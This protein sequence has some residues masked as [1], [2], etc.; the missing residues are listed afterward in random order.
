MAG[1]LSAFRGSPGRNCRG[2]ACLRSCGREAGRLNAVLRN[3]PGARPSKL[4]PAVARLASTGVCR[5]NNVGGC[6]LGWPVEADV[7]GGLFL[8]AVGNAIVP[9]RI[10]DKKIALHVAKL[11]RGQM[12][13]SSTAS[14]SW[15]TILEK[16]VENLSAKLTHASQLPRGYNA[17]DSLLVKASRRPKLQL[18]RLGRAHVWWD[19]L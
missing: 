17:A 18:P 15:T 10:R 12:R 8:I 9:A 5:V 4:T 11:E 3:A 6:L 1:P 13:F 7:D 14:H 19:C 16:A 2:P